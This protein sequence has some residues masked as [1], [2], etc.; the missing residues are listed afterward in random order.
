MACTS[1][2]PVVI[3]ELMSSPHF[4][5]PYAA[6]RRCLIRSREQRRWASMRPRATLSSRRCPGA[7]RAAPHRVG[8]A[9]KAARRPRCTDRAACRAELC[10]PCS[11]AHAAVRAG[12]GALPAGSARTARCGRVTPRRPHSLRRNRNPTRCG[13][14][15]AGLDSARCRESA[16]LATDGEAARP[17]EAEIPRTDVRSATKP[18]PNRR[19]CD[20]RLPGRLAQK[21]V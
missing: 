5:D 15:P 14:D 13:H 8:G 9:H 20:R 18:A 2:N 6:P 11:R 19:L 16:G 21:G 4:A 12:A 7:F 3:T 1:W 17:R 10:T